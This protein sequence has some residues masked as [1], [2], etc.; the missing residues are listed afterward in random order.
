MD[1]ETL[2][3]AAE[4]RR[5][6]AVRRFDVLDT[7]PD[8]AFDRITSMA[9][10]L[11]GVP[12]AIVSIVDTD[13]VWFKSH[14]GIDVDEIGREPGPCASAVLGDAPGWCPTRLRIRV[15]SPTRWSPVR[16]GCASTPAFRSPP[17]TATTWA[18]CA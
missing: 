4:A 7:P 15:R 16:W 13:R 1:D 3:A 18:R 10:R 17:G 2:L 12:I 9:A 14:H 11:L 5:M 8:G 6:A